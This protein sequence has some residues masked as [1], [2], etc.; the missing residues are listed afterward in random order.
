MESQVLPVGDRRSMLENEKELQLKHRL[1]PG[2]L[3]EASELTLKWLQEEE[4]RQHDPFP[5][6]RRIHYK[7]DA[8]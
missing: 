6:Q 1:S 7:R 3:L 2:V 5:F 4:S 8:L